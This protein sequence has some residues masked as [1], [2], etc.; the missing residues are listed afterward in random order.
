MELHPLLP[1]SLIAALLFPLAA[2]RA[3]GDSQWPQ[4]MTDLDQY[5]DL[6]D[7]MTPDQQTVCA[8]RIVNELNVRIQGFDFT[9]D[10]MAPIQMASWT[11]PRMGLLRGGGYNIRIV[12]SEL[13][14]KQVKK[15]K[16]GRYATKFD[17]LLDGVSP[18]LHVPG[19]TLGSQL[20]LKTKDSVDFTAHI[21]SAFAYFPA[22]ALAHLFVDVI[23]A[24]T[25]DPCP[26]PRD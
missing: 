11:S 2:A 5:V 16:A 9:P 22:G 10:D 13:S 23:G 20:L 6:P 21:D 17:W 26:L 1:C 14:E 8:Q 18:S 7:R 12:K 19:L 24:D 4:W 15:V 3:D 25:R